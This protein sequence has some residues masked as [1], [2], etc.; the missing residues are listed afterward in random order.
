MLIIFL[1]STTVLLTNSSC[2]PGMLVVYRLSLRTEWN[3]K[4]FPKQFPQW[5]PS[6][7][8]S[9][10]IG[11]SHSSTPAA[12]LFSIG[13]AVS[14]GVRLF[15]ET[16]ATDTLDLEAANKTFLDAIIS[17]PIKQ[18]VGETTTTIFVDTNH[19]KVSVMTKLVPSPDWFV[20]L[21]SLDLCS[22]GVFIESVTTEAFPLDAGTDN[23]FTF[24][25]PNWATQPRGEV[26]TM[27]STF[28]AH[29]AGS[30]N[31]PHLA[32][33]PTLAVY[34]LTKLREYK[35]HGQSGTSH[36]TEQGLTLQDNYQATSVRTAESNTNRKLKYDV[37]DTLKESTKDVPEF[38]PILTSAH[39]KTLTK[40]V[41]NEIPLPESTT[42]F[43]K[44]KIHLLGSKPS[45]GFRSSSSVTGYHAST[46]P[47]NFFKKK[48]ESKHLNKAQRKLFSGPLARVPA[49]ELYQ[50]ILAQYSKGGITLKK[51]KIRRR[52]YRRH[53]KPVNCLVSAW[54]AWG[55]CSKTCGIGESSRSRVISHHPL[56]GGQPCPPLTDYKW[57][58][59]ARNCNTGYFKW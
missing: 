39:K 8:W 37:I 23:G 26:F 21:D 1:L 55:E 7:Q 52:K 14:E 11:Y 41:S 25:S 47:E 33:L 2:L 49:S 12:P 32:R 24:T 17:P 38:D 18:G 4:T 57:C 35:L 42:R 6:A 20:G 10:T 51:K 46:S 29:P 28:P 16:G 48:Y 56:H 9:K 3:E 27:T 13:S 44:K 40:I 59:S 58:G 43:K 54:S 53:R 45:T 30:F 34:S 5:R 36:H 31:Y 15:A 50:H 19:T 22:Q